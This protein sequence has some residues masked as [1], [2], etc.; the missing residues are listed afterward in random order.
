MRRRDFL[1]QASAAAL[2][3][4]LPAPA[5]TGSRQATG[6]KIGEVTDTS[7]I[8]WMRLTAAQARRWDGILRRGRPQPFAPETRI[9]DLEGACPG[10]PGRVRL[11]VSTRDD[12]RKA[13]PTRWLDV[14]PTADFTAQFPLTGLKPDTVYFYAAETAGHTGSMH[15]PLTGTFRTAPRPRDPASVSFT[16]TTCQ[17]YSQLDHNEGF[18]IYDSMLRLS[19]HFF[20]SAGD[21][22]YYDSDD[23]RAT[24]PELARYHWQRMFSFPRHMRLLQNV[25]GYWAKDDHDTLTDDTWPTQPQGP[26]MKLTFEQGLGI[27]REQVPMGPR[28]YRTFRWGKTLQIW[29]VEGRDFRS[30]NPMPDGPEKTIWGVAQKEW[31]KRSLLASDADWKILVSPTPIVGPDRTNKRDNHSNLSFAHEGREFREWARAHLGES[32]FNI[33]GDRHWQ[34][35]S[36][37]PETGTHEFSVGAASDS[38]AGGS[39][40]FDP[41]FH[42]FHLV[43]GG[44]LHVE[45]AR[46]GRESHIHF[47]LRNVLGGVTYQFSRARKVS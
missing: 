8:A 44:F 11:L 16:M 36:V 21:I 26:E 35:H 40:G 28:T 37:H 27:F 7:A 13:R 4:A 18:H 46:A 19:P 6:L 32:F 45:T 17:K 42:R 22:V 39:P 31:L 2:A 47:R 3:H 9:E 34:Y 29:L 41:R 12:L 38:H 14:S 25:P 5:A 1:M 20:I 15:D 23:P 10:A 30:P 33:N 43:K 24:T